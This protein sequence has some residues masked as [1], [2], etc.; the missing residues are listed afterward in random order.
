MDQETK[1]KLDDLRNEQGKL[2]HDQRE[3]LDKAD[4]EKRD[5]TADEETNYQNMDKRYDEVT[6]AIKEINDNENKEKAEA[7]RKQKLQEREEKLRKAT[8]RKT[9]LE[10]EK[11]E[12]RKKEVGNPNDKF[13][14]Y[15]LNKRYLDSIENFRNKTSGKYSSEE[16]VRTYRKYLIYGVNQLSQDERHLLESRALAA[17]N[18]SYGGFLVAPEKLQMQLIQKLDNML[19]VRRLGNVMVLNNAAS[20][21]A[22]ALETDPDDGDW[23][24]E[25]RTG[26]E[27]STMK[28]DKRSL[29]PHPLAKRI[30]VSKT[31]LRISAMPVEN[32]VS[33]RIFYKMN[34][35]LEQNYLTGDGQGKPLGVFTASAQGI[36]TDRDV[37][38]GSQTAITSDSLRDAKYK[39][40]KQ[41]RML[42]DLRWTFHRDAIKMI[43]KLKTGD[44][45]Y[46]WKQGIS[47]D[48]P[49]TILGI[50]Y[51]E[52]E[53]VPNTFTSGLYVGA[54]AAWRY[55]WIVD[56]L[57]M[58]IQVL[59]ELYAETNQN[60][61]IA[62]YEGDGMPVLSKAFVRLK[63]A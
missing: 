4:N 32:I 40:E 7:E 33:E 8:G 21:G 50:P 56:A 49:D 55:Y 57:S 60:G 17:D 39:L 13:V 59:T 16:Y 52:S 61:Y 3:L 36:N 2:T 28:F 48:D 6:D 53:Y 1:K 45:D 38:T 20:L 47:T 30:K 9:E 58:S 41:Y 14:E 19:F 46:I 31:L 54:L 23:T 51:E 35:P 5:L 12:K 43:S 11:E 26:S 62:R 42:P 44:G 37:S 27:D 34:V 24:A 63:T 22:P 25:I 29:T 15:D 18:D 10:I